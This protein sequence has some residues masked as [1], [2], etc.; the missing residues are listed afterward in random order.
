M[1]V[2]RIEALRVIN[3]DHDTVCR[4][5]LRCC[6]KSPNHRHIRLLVQK[7]TKRSFTIELKLKNETVTGLRES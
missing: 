5:R 2:T 4:Q 6:D 7:L 1:M 3:L